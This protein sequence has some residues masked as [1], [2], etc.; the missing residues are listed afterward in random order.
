MAVF[1]KLSVGDI[2]A[3]SG[4][5]VFRKLTTDEPEIALEA[6]LYDADD[7]L[8]ADWDELVNTYGLDA[9]RDYGITSYMEAST[10]LYGVLKNNTHLSKSTTL[11]VGG[12]TVGM[13]AFAGCNN[14]T[15]IIFSDSVTTIAPATFG[16]CANLVSVT[17]GRNVSNLGDGYDKRMV[18]LDCPNLKCIKVARGNLYYANDAS[19]VLFNK[20]KTHL[21]YAPGAL[22][23]VYTIPDGVVSIE[24]MAFYQSSILTSVIIPASVIDIGFRAFSYCYDIAS[25]RVDED[26]T[27]YSSDENGVLFDKEKTTLFVAP[28]K[29]VG[30]YVIPNTVTTISGVAFIDC[31][32]LT[33]IIIPDGVTTIEAAA[34]QG[35]S[36]LVSL[37]IP[38]SVTS[39]DNNMF[40][41]CDN[42]TSVVVGNGVTSIGVNMFLYCA[43]LTTVTLGASVEVIDQYAF[44]SCP[45]LTSITIPDRVTNI[46]RG[47]FHSCKKM[48]YVILPTSV[49]TIE[50][51]AFYNCAGLTDVYY[52]GTKAQWNAISIA[53]NNSR[54]TN[55]TI[56]YNYTD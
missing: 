6:G 52:K 24:K 48:S 50:D 38:D 9:V 36:S 51:S 40:Y 44:S 37:T 55:A 43:K 2:V 27:F 1:N 4:T 26:N 3:S 25:I 23:G 28:K 11:V 5:R 34:F 29:L 30:T 56:H 13:F 49:T 41:R 7:N 14:L 46:N 39:L 31:P 42:M 54:L 35:C 19:G 20:E 18:F 53:G 16:E 33:N 47:A 15:T 32:Y 21:Y 17:I 10:N 45:N 12:S 22:N 8:V